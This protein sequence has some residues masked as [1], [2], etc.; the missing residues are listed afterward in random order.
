MYHKAAFM[1]NH[2]RQVGCVEED[3]EEDGARTAMWYV[4]QHGMQNHGS[5]GQE[6]VEFLDAVPGIGH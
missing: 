3:G 4:V 2:K 1:M 6:L 5:R